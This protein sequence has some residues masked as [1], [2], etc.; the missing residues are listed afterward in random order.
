MKQ[1]SKILQ[2]ITANTT[3]KV[4]NLARIATIDSVSNQRLCLNT[5]ELNQIGDAL[6]RNTSVK[7]LRWYG[8]DISWARD[9]LFKLRVARPDLK[10]MPS[11]G[12]ALPF[13]TA[14][15]Q[16]ANGLTNTLR[17]AAVCDFTES[18]SANIA[19]VSIATSEKVI[20]CC[21]AFNDERVALVYQSNPKQVSIVNFDTYAGEVL[22]ES[23][24]Q[25]RMLYASQDSRLLVVTETNSIEVWD[26]NT[27]RCLRK[28]PNQT[29]HIMAVFFSSRSQFLTASD[30]GS[31]TCWNDAASGD[32][33]LFLMPSA[34]TS[35]L[36]CFGSC[37]LLLTKAGT[38]C[39]TT[40]TGEVKQ[41]SND[42]CTTGLSLPPDKTT[43]IYARAPA[44]GK[45]AQLIKCG[46]VS[47]DALTEVHTDCQFAQS[48]IVALCA[49]PDGKRFAS[50]T[51]D[52]STENSDD[53][54]I[55]RVSL[56]DNATLQHLG[57]IYQNNQSPP[58][59]LL[60]LQVLFDGKLLLIKDNGI[61]LLDPGYLPCP[62][63]CEQLQTL[64]ESMRNTET[65][66]ILDL[67]G[68][69]AL[70][71][72]VEMELV[73]CI[74]DRQRRNRNLAIIHAEIISFPEVKL[75]LFLI[76]A[77]SDPSVTELNLSGMELYGSGCECLC[78]MLKD[79]NKH[80]TKINLTFAQLPEEWVSNLR[81]ALA[82]KTPSPQVIGFPAW[83]A[84]TQDIVASRRYPISLFHS[85]VYTRSPLCDSI[86]E[87]DEEEAESS[88][89]AP[90]VS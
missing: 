16:I 42:D 22:G 48:K 58:S 2:Q 46:V 27:K 84:S 25:V 54:P 45:P 63:N 76:K 74:L 88:Q 1:F 82:G 49:L 10:I 80:L 61:R 32:M 21:C 11:C 60:D 17:V 7:T 15:L 72:G 19:K 34:V 77:R 29:K 24:S 47:G 67:S 81:E 23:D 8:I 3:D 62:I 57:V 70:Q 40:D 26:I 65:V 56:W 39:W 78:Y 59:R 85:G 71:G 53:M 28:I 89:A 31:I 68:I 30:D 38:Y 79:P 9:N 12:Y 37:I 36:P 50:L 20:N 35:M 43:V 44:N 83:Y 33:V 18:A 6:K 41:V 55:H 90:F 75:V 51:W 52:A 14:I 5:A 87:L 66:T 4:L 86:L 69:A 13:N 73:E 64:F